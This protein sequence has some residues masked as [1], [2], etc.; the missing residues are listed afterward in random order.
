MAKPDPI[1][2]LA[3]DILE[4]SAWFNALDPSMKDELSQPIHDQQM[5]EKGIA[6]ARLVAEH[7]GGSPSSLVREATP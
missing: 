7:N 5:A 2:A 3:A 4:L 6:L 1:A